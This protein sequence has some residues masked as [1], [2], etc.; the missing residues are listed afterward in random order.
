VG[1]IVGGQTSVKEPEIAAF[2]RHLPGDVHIVTCHSMH[3][4][5]VDPKGQPLVV[6]CHRCPQPQYQK[7]LIVLQSLKSN[8]VE[9]ADYKL[10]D[11]ITADTQA[12]T[13]LAFMS[14]GAG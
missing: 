12:V 1:A 4:P 11:Q 13:H 7:A 3:A 8:I 6:I 9:L 14:M 10:H 5:S 2:E